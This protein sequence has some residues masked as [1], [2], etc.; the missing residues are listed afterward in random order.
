MKMI[1]IPL[2]YGEKI[3]QFLTEVMNN[4]GQI[5]V[6]EKE[7]AIIQVL[8]PDDFNFMPDAEQAI[9]ICINVGSNVALSLLSSW[10]YDKLKDRKKNY[11]VINGEKCEVRDIETMKKLLNE[12]KK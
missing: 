10:L 6:D 5:V 2:I 1:Q 3:P 4:A 9:G 12:E 11:I 7:N 8:P